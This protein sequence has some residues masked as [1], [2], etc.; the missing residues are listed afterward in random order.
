MKIYAGAQAPV[1]VD[2]LVQELLP[3][4][5]FRL[6]LALLSAVPE[7]V[8]RRARCP[9]GGRVRLRTD[10][11]RVTVRMA[12]EATRVDWAIPLSGSAGAPVYVGSAAS[13]RFAGLLCP[14][15]YTETAVTCTFEKA[16]AMEDVTIFLPRN[17]VVREVEIELEDGV[18]ITPPTPYAIDTPIVFYGSSI[19]EGGC[20][21]RVTNAYPALLGKWLDADII[22][23][24]F[25]GAAKGE[26]ALADYIATLRMSAFVYDYDHNAPS[27]THLETTHDAFFQ[28][29]RRRQPTLPILMLSRPDVDGNRQEAAL[30][31][32]V[33]LRTYQDALAQGD[34]RVAFLDGERLLGTADR[35]ACTV[36]GCH[37]NDLGFMRFAKAVYPVLRGLLGDDP[38][39]NH[40]ETED[41]L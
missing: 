40:D 6:P 27:V 19:T 15:S 41:T 1:E 31:R 4:H 9:V 11:P 33:I 17:E 24:G 29:I 16:A 36:D 20:A 5:F 21:S 12:L 2:G 23:L 26:A 13:P 7:G 38:N 3:Q 35:E 32:D 14:R 22:N 37:P 34:Q 8:A 39:I 10:S 28:A 30:R 18:D 25:S